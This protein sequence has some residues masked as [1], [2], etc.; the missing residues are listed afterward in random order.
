M[1]HTLVCDARSKTCPCWQSLD[2]LS[3]VAHRLQPYLKATS[4]LLALE[5]VSGSKICDQGPPDTPQELI[6]EV[7]KAFTLYGELYTPFFSGETILLD[8]VRAILDGHGE[9]SAE[10]E[11]RFV[12]AD[13][14]K[15]HTELWLSL[16]C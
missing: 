11:F 2:I 12:L 14:T 7:E 9:C 10:D 8:H 3:S 15:G 4:L 5:R 13:S 1:D 16:V 6:E